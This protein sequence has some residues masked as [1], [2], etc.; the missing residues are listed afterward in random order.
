MADLVISCKTLE[1]TINRFLGYVND[2]LVIHANG[3]SSPEYKIENLPVGKFHILI[4]VFSTG[5]ARYNV[6]IDL[7]GTGS[8]VDANR[9]FTF[10]DTFEH[11]FENFYAIYNEEL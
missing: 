2:Q 4:K 9:S 7:P 6:K 11:K 5:N 1:G 3:T 8:D 10:Q